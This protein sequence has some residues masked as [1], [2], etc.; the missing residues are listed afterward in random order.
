MKTAVLCPIMAV[1][2][3]QAGS[4][5]QAEDPPPCKTAIT[6]AVRLVIDSSGIEGME[7]DGTRSEPVRLYSRLTSKLAA[8]GIGVVDDAAIKPDSVPPAN[9]G[10]FTLKLTGR[11][12]EVAYREITS[13]SNGAIKNF[14]SG[15]SLKGTMTI[16]FGEKTAT[17]EFTS[18]GSG[19]SI[20]DLLP[21]SAADAP[22][23]CAVLENPDFLKSL[24]KRLEPLVGFDNASRAL[25]HGYQG[26]SANNASPDTLT[27]VHQALREA[28]PNASNWL[29]QELRTPCDSIRRRVVE[30]MPP[31]FYEQLFQ[32]EPPDELFR[33]SDACRG[34]NAGG[35]KELIPDL[36]IVLTTAEDPLPR[37][38]AALR[39]VHIA[40]LRQS[41]SDP[42]AVPDLK[43]AR[44][45]ASGRARD[46]IENALSE[47]DPFYLRPGFILAVIGVVVLLAAV[48]IVANLLMK[49]FEQRKKAAASRPAP[50]PA[51]SKSKFRCP[52]C[53]Y[54]LAYLPQ[55]AGKEAACPK[56]EHRVRLPG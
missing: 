39:L 40:R 1:L 24:H 56:C 25:I 9:L 45:V 8:A 44:D 7:T 6:H 51:N 38:G 34:P 41:K 48:A 23:D 21:A 22:F 52:N 29:M 5:V 10:E 32:S 19:W 12:Y 26:F 31:Q 55:H 20:P 49:E 14:F 47:L 30:V 3:W 53:Q 17:D 43:S 13:G 33:I 16:R 46:I 15:I 42:G 27:I 54:E 2:L 50:K 35:S 36:L 28:R 4:L 18:E 11:A 37:E